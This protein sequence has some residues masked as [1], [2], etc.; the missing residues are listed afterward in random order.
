MNTRAGTGR[1]V[2]TSVVGM[3]TSALLFAGVI[4]AAADPPG[5]NGTVKIAGEDADVG[6]DSHV[7]CAFTVD[8]FGYDEGD[9]FADYTI[10]ATAPTDDGTVVAGFV[11]IGGD[12]AGGATDLDAQAP[13]DLT[14]AFTG[15][16]QDEQAF[17]VR[18]TV[19]ADGSQGADTK[20]KTFWVDCAGEDE[21]EG[22]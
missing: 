4:T 11:F 17:H 21:G 10:E 3:V 6:N 14:G 22:E 7:G 20:H 12:P 16:P 13:V 5:N 15:A 9:L 2:A 18:L 1:F 8:F 19:H